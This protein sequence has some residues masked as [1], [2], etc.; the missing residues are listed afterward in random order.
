[1]E[2]QVIAKLYKRFMWYLV[3]L[4][5]CTV[6][7]RVN[8]GFAALQMN[9]ALNLSHAVFGLAAS[10]F[11]AGYLLFDVPSNMLMY[12]FGARRFISRI[13]VIWGL[14][15]AATCM[16]AGATSLL[17]L[18]FIL[19]CAEAGFLPGIL[20][21]LGYWFPNQH[22]ARANA[23]LLVAM[24]VSQTVA[25]ILASFIFKLDGLA[26]LAGWKW[27][28]LIEGIFTVL[29]GLTAAFYLTDRPSAAKWLKEEERDWL[30]NQLALEAQ[31]LDKRDEPAW[32]KVLFDK[33]V[34][35]LGAIYF[36]LDIPLTAIPV[37]LP[38]IVR[39]FG[40]SIGLTGLLAALPPL[41]GA[42]VM[43]IWS[44]SSDVK[45]ERTW[46]LAGALF[47]CSAGWA[48]TIIAHGN[49]VMT[50]FGVVLA[51][52]GILAALSIFWSLPAMILQGAAAA[53]GIGLLSAIGNVGS[54]I[55]P[56]LIGYARDLT[57]SFRGAF[58]GLASAA[59]ISALLVLMVTRRSVKKTADG[60]VT[61]SL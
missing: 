41:I 45:R 54:M 7:D 48:L 60:T 51:N 55:A 23:V 9:K 43:V 50:I 39:S 29:V 42:V 30:E 21:Y 17:S 1:M 59:F 24:P 61:T 19:G 36:F 57:G 6:I 11:A 47:M 34:L 44:R 27:F 37:W 2:K 28:F 4:F 40:Y 8:I 58:M 38:Q 5:F 46:H 22:R 49:P 52:G 15:T 10:A 14:I 32:W 16:V 13:M 35:A 3:I 12:K 26:G 18:R 20:L 53:V 31:V 56:V 33:R 25:S